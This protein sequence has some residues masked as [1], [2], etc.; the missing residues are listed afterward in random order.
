MLG[1]IGSICLSFCGLPQAIHSIKVGNSDGLTYSFLMLWTIGELFTLKAVAL[2][3]PLN[4]LIFNYVSN[5][6][7]LSIIWYY[8]LLRR[9]VQ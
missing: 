1:W 4:Y 7:F 9:V 5:L 8:K 6:V 2:D 3:I